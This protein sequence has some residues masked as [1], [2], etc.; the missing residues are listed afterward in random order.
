MQMANGDV[1]YNKTPVRKIIIS[2]FGDCVADSYLYRLIAM[3]KKGMQTL[4][5]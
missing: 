3:E 4:Q 1:Y 5:F 2:T